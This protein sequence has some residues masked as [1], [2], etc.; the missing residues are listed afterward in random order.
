MEYG[1]SKVVFA[2]KIIFL[3]RNKNLQAPYSVFLSFRLRL[4]QKHRL[5]VIGFSGNAQNVFVNLLE[6]F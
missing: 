1:I 4:V 3:K 5:H 2:V 6:F